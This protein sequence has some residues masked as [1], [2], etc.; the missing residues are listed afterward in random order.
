[1]FRTSIFGSPPRQLIIDDH[2]DDRVDEL[3]RGADDVQFAS[4]VL[5]AAVKES[6]EQRADRT[7][8]ADHRHGYAV[9]AVALLCGEL[10]DASDDAENLHGASEPREQAGDA[11]KSRTFKNA[12][13]RKGRSQ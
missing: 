11:H 2:A 13:V 5:H 6:R 4:A 7:D 12:I 10:R 3:A 8:A 1:V 9:E